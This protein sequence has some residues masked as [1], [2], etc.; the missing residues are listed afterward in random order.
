[1][2]DLEWNMNNGMDKQKQDSFLNTLVDLLRQYE[3]TEMLENK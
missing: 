3:D 2:E 1:M